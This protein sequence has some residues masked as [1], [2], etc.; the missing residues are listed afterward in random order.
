MV[1]LNSSSVSWLGHS[2]VL[3]FDVGILDVRIVAWTFLRSGWWRCHSW[4]P[5]RRI[6]VWT[7]S[8][9]VWW[10]CHSWCPD[11]G[12]VVFEVRVVALSFLK[13][14]SWRGRSWGPGG[15][16]VILDDR[17]AGSWRGRSRGPSG[18]VVILDVRIVA[19]SFLISGSWRI[20]DW[21]CGLGIIWSLI[22]SLHF[23]LGR[24]YL[25]IES[26]F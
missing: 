3:V 24:R 16:V 5:D 20:L 4:W 14:G 11:C 22:P 25:W 2:W 1:I 10:R 9:S 19:W 7:F 23:C 8:R 13:S 15:G 17:I 21:E 6:V 18:D 26:S 12:L